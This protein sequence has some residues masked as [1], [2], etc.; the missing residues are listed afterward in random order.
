MFE[1]E[2][3]PKE[4]DEAAESW[5]DFVRE[6]KDYYRE[7]MNNP[8]FF[9]L[10]GNVKGMRI[11]DLSCGEGY[12]TRI[13]AKMGGEV[14]GVDFSEKMVE[15]AR[16][17]EIEENLGIRYYIS[18]AASL[19][20]FSSN[21]FDMVTCFMS[22]MDIEHYEDAVSEVARVLK[23]KGR[24]VF[25]ITH[26][27]FEWGV[28][29]DGEHLADWKYEEGTENTPSE[30][31]LCLEVRSY[32][33]VVKYKVSWTMKRLA[34]PFKTTSFHRTFSG[35]FQALSD[36]GFLIAK[37]VEP[38]PTVAGVSKHPSLRKHVKIPHSVVIEAVK[39]TTHSACLEKD[40]VDGT[41][42]R[43]NNNLRHVSLGDP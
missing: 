9:R 15:L 38:R 1:D 31:A 12:N 20:E 3:L 16:Q 40:A 4:W 32:N 8:A 19:K 22:L 7:E 26:P 42:E 14:I 30:K 17:K 39:M 34:K 13:L 33:D 41:H 43:F 28:S 21:F 5:A 2:R 18:D 27:C 24:F 6:G 35:Y 11:L 23:E 36:S 25:S 10:V 37:L 29:I